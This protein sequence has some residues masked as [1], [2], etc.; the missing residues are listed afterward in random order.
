M[1]RKSREWAV[2][3]SLYKL[4]AFV[5]LYLSPNYNSIKHMSPNSI[6]HM[7]AIAYLLFPVD[8]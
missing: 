3:M 2:G 8:N 7:R 1:S 6:K 4:I 5:S